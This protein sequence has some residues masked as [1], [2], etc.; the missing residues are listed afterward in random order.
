MSCTQTKC[1]TPFVGGENNQSP[2]TL[3]SIVFK[4]LMKSLTF[5]VGIIQMQKSPHQRANWSRG[6]FRRRSEFVGKKCLQINNTSNS[7]WPKKRGN[8]LMQQCRCGNSPRSLDV[9]SPSFFFYWE[10]RGKSA[11]TARPTRCRPL[12]SLATARQADGVNL[13][14]RPL[15]GATVYP[16]PASEKMLEHGGKSNV[17]PVQVDQNVVRVCCDNG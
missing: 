8:T 15:G 13:T 11:R 7:S 3:P 6:F 17:S 1:L 12:A 2:N 5:Y 16:P 10:K 4:K 9:L 14:G